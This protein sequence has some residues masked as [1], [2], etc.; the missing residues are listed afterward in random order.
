MR[1]KKT[2]IKNGNITRTIPFTRV[3]YL[4]V[5][6]EKKSVREDVYVFTM[7]YSKDEAEKALK[8]MGKAVAAIIEVEVYERKMVI[9]YLSFVAYAHLAE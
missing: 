9:D 2:A 8:E 3:Q 4:A 6:V 5:D 1:T 7:E